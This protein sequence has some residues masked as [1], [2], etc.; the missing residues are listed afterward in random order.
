MLLQSLRRVGASPL[1][2]QHR[3][4]ALR[5]LSTKVV[6]HS[7]GPDR[8]GVLKEL[9]MV[10][11][12]HGGKIVDTRAVSLDG[13]RLFYLFIAAAARMH[14]PSHFSPHAFLSFSAQAPFRSPRRSSCPTTAATSRGR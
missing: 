12:G 14:T 11:L 9:T 1:L 5:A 7:V 4:M 2:A 8:V 6:V 3:S 13:A 10:M